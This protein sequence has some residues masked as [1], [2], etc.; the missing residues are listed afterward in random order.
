MEIVLLIFNNLNSEMH[1][2][3]HEQVRYVFGEY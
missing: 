3:A 2:A 1:G